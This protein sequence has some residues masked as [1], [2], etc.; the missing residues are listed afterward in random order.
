MFRLSKL[1]DYSIVLLSYFAHPELGGAPLTAKA[2]SATAE[3]PLPTVTKLL[4]KLAKGGL[5]DSQ[6][7]VQGG[8]RLARPAD[9]ITVLAVIAAIDGPVEL[10]DC[11]GTAPSGCELEGRCPSRSNWRRIND[12]VRHS[13]EALTI[14]DMTRPRAAPEASLVTLVR[15]E[16][17]AGAK[18]P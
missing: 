17:Q 8:Y 4:K 3:I 5:L 13:L 2:L 10:T 9:Q 7:G 6:R 12:A 14:R 18:A 1:T 11:A 16:H 15:R